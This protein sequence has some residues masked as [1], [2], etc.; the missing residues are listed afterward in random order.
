MGEFGKA[1]QR[2]D[3]H[4]LFGA[5][6]AADD[7]HR[8]VGGAA[9]RQQL[10]LQGR[11]GKRA[12][13]DHQR[14]PRLRQRRPMQS[15]VALA[16]AGDEGHGLG[17]VAVGERDA[18]VGGR[19]EGGGDA[20]DDAAGNAR[21]LQGLRLLAATAKDEGVAAFQAHYPQSGARV[22]DEQVMNFALRDLRRASAFA[23][24]DLCRVLADEGA[25]VV[26][27]QRVVENHIRRLQGL[28]GVKGEQSGIARPGADQRDFA[29]QRRLCRQLARDF[30]LRFRQAVLRDQGVEAAGK[31]AFP[32]TAARF[33]PLH[34]RLDPRPPAS[35]KCRQ[36]AA[37]TRQQQL[38]LL[39]PMAGKHRC[40]SRAGNGNLQRRAVY[41]RWH[42]IRA[43]MRCIDHIAQFARR[44]RRRENA[45][46]QLAIAGG[47]D[48]EKDAVG[49]RRCKCRAE[50]CDASGSEPV[51]KDGREFTRDH[52]QPRPGAQE[53]FG[54][55]RGDVSG[56]HQQHRAV[57]QV[58]KQRKMTAHDAIS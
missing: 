46:V 44:F 17:V 25:D 55:A 20:G 42:D 33:R 18:S 45:R 51:L 15:A 23:D 40:R 19:A 53:V 49:L 22:A 35:G 28:Q 38:D 39:A 26:R 2:A 56:T 21:R 5:C 31:E 16:V 58:G 43:A 11:C 54:L 52:A 37:V 10:P 32:E 41:H 3:A 24:A 27:N 47:G 50:V 7:R 4:L 8:R 48:D 6:A 29:A 57:V 30:R 14:V 12:H 34:R 1:R 36:R 9:V 13:I